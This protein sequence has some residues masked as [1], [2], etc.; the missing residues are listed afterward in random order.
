MTLSEVNTFYFIGIGGIG[1]SAL[2]RYFHRQGHHVMG[3]DRTSSAL[4]T[5]LEMEG[6]DLTFNDS[7]LD[8]PALLRSTPKEKVLVVY[9]PAI[10]VENR[11]LHWFLEQ[12]YTVAKRSAVLGMI[13]ATAPTAAIA[14]THGKTTTASML[15]HLLHDSGHRCNAFLGGIAANYR[16][17]LIVAN[18]GDWNV[19]EADEFDR[20]FLS[21][22]PNLAVITSVDADHLDIY[23]EHAELSNAFNAFANLVKDDDGLLVCDKASFAIERQHMTYGLTDE[24]DYKGS[25]IY[26]LDGHA[27]FDLQLPDGSEV[28]ELPLRMPG[29]HN[30]ENAIAAIAIALKRGVDHDKLRHALRTFTGVRRRYEFQVEREDLVY[31]DDYAHHPEELRATIEATRTMYPGKHLLGIFQPHLFSRTRDHG[32]AFAES[33]ALLDEVWLLEIY[34]AREKPIPGIDSQWLLD[35]IQNTPKKQVSKSHLLDELKQHQTEVLLTLGAGDIDRLVAPIREHLQT[36]EE[37]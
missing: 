8:L 10:P 5:E 9:T 28:K 25:E 17:N 1:M 30:Q 27:Y 35:K 21:L 16:S 2:A 22:H 18:E 3:Y 37:A 19:V 33:L 4:T 36:R 12:E 11:L 23:G 29:R 14:G 6:I 26:Q 32:D 20:S 15:A 13:T 34:P 31:I 24:A 7:T